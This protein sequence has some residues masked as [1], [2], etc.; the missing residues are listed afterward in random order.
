M[1]MRALA[2]RAVHPR[3]LH[4][5]PSTNNSCPRLSREQLFLLLTPLQSLSISHT[6]LNAISSARRRRWT[7]NNR[8]LDR[9]EH[10]R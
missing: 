10:L 9:A 3:P 4:A 8:A 7:N 2:L 6:P 1:R 5:L